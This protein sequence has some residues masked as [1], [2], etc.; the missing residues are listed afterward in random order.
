MSPDF[1][2]SMDYLHTWS[3]VLFGALLFLIFFMGSLSVFNREIDRWMM[4]AT[5]LPAPAGPV[6]ID[7]AALPHLQALAPDATS[8]FIVYPKER[9]PTL[10]IGWLRS[11]ASFVT[12]DIDPVTHRLL[13]ETGSPGGTR[14]FYP[15]H[16]SLH[17]RWLDL[18]IWLVGLASMAMLAALVSGVVIHRRI[19]KDFFT[20]RPHKHAGR[21]V[22]DLHNVTSVL[23][24]PFH[25]T[26]TLSGLIIFYLIYMNAGLHIV[27]G[28]DRQAYFKEAMGRYERPAAGVPGRLA[29]VDA[30]V[31]QAVLLWGDARVR[32]VAIRNPNDARAVVEVR[33]EPHDRVA[34][35]TDT[36]YFDGATGAVLA[37]ESMGPAMRAQRFISGLHFVAFEHGWLRWLYFLMGL[38]SCVMIAT[39]LLLW[40]EKRRSKHAPSVASGW[41]VVEATSCAGTLGVLV[42]TLAMLAAN[43]LLPEALAGRL[44]WEMGVFF[45][46]W[47]ASGVHAWRAAHPWRGQTLAVAILG[48]A[49]PA[50]NGLTTGD[51]LV[52]T[53][54][55]GQWT[56]AGVDLVLLATGFVAGMAWRRLRFRALR[57]EPATLAL[58]ESLV[59]EER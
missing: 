56:I 40:L 50:L 18:G 15:F 2:R 43:R 32:S 16:Y 34:Y 53:I 52:K 31:E 8:W 11:D 26:I 51:H 57:P 20:F 46:V 24:L 10:R 45:A 19:F 30:M 27:Y 5:R 1:R 9:E 25:F 58:G 13:P 39:G 55:G 7:R 49:V 59:P 33:R 17:L 12:R 6:S 47:L 3:G 14:F 54:A 38:A 35:V 22:L 21:A 36:V 41:R 29:S 4:P 28:G 48:L 42:A 44:Q 37:R 23:C